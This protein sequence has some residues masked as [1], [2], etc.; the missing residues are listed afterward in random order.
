[1]A[2]TIKLA[3]SNHLVLI[4]FIQRLQGTGISTTVLF[5]IFGGCSV[6]QQRSSWTVKLEGKGRVVLPD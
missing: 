1:M 4:V 5:Q 3:L 2:M 6:F